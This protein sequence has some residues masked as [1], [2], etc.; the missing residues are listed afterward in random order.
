MSGKFSHITS[1]LDIS[2]LKNGKYI[3][4][5]TDN[6]NKTTVLSFVKI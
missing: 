6:N 3:L 1:D 5:I 2:T 4:T